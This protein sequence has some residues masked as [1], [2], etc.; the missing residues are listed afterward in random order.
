MIKEIDLSLEVLKKG[1]LK[2]QLNN[3]KKRLK[4]L[5]RGILTLPYTYKLNNFIVNHR[6][7]KNKVY[8]YP[9][10]ISKIHRP[11]L[12]LNSDI[13]MK[14]KGIINTYRILDENL[15]GNLLEK[16]YTKGYIEIG[17]VE[18]KDG[19][20]YTIRFNIY[21]S[22]DK[23]GEASITIF[24]PDKI[25]LGTVTFSILKIKGKNI[26]FIG[27]I[28]GAKR[29]ID[30]DFIKQNSKNLYGIFPKKL[31][32]ESLYFLD[33]SFDFVFDK[34]AV[35]NDAHVYK[36]RR[37]NRKR[38]IKADYDEFWKSLESKKEGEIWKLPEII[39]RKKIEDVPSK[40][41]SQERKKYFLL[42]KLENSINKK[43]RE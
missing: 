10:L 21:T 33:K 5:L 40:K 11:Y 31:L 26:I 9:I 20:K 36:A 38:V 39:H 22:F 28:Q 16:L 12:Y 19:G 8:D 23:E 41:R 43:I 4:Y 14:V 18:G 32:I 1:E 7:L 24:S 25:K 37:Y 17:E 6:Y 3:R 34:Y 42:E 29:D 30:K 13:S 2:A 27:G 15:S 35:G